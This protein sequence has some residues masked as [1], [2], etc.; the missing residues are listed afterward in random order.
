MKISTKSKGKCKETQTQ[1][2]RE[3]LDSEPSDLESRG[4]KLIRSAKPGNKWTQHELHAFNIR[5]KDEMEEEFFDLRVGSRL[6]ASTTD[7]TVLSNIVMPQTDTG[8]S[9]SARKFFRYLQHATKDSSP[10]R[11]T[12]SAVDDFA[13]QR[14]RELRL[15]AITSAYS[16]RDGDQLSHVWR[17]NNES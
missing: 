6:P 2:E 3:D 14:E 5:I 10:D 17:E 11:S 16:S 12:E 8:I 15:R 1:P 13:S 7:P 9:D 4:S